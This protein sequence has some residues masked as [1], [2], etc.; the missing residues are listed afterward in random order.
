MLHSRLRESGGNTVRK[1]RGIS[2]FLPFAH[3]AYFCWRDKK[4]IFTYSGLFALLLPALF[5]C[6]FSEAEGGW[7][8]LLFR[9]YDTPENLID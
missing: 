5:G 9:T 8:L 7:R 3:S 6:W 1:W 2:N 4:L